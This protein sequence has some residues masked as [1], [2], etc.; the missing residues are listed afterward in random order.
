MAEMRVGAQM[1]VGVSVVLV[2]EMAVDVTAVV[3]AE[4]RVGEEVATEGTPHHC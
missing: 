3:V 4:M 1:R 2:A